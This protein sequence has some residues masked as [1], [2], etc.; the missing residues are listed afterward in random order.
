MRSEVKWKGRMTPPLGFSEEL[1]LCE[2]HWLREGQSICLINRDVIYVI[3]YSHLT[4][5]MLTSLFNF[6]PHSKNFLV[7]K[8]LVAI[9]QSAQPESS[10][11][12]RL[13]GYDWAGLGRCT[14]KTSETT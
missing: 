13:P 1:V 11:K 7:R 8:S 5:P 3:P 12:G 9:A 14:T 6:V 10:G 2:S 4:H